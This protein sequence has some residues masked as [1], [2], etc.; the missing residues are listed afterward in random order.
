MTMT[1]TMALLAL[2]VLPASVRAQQNPADRLAEVLPADV[3]GQVLDVIAAAQASGLPGGAVANLALEGV[4]KGR[5]SDEVLAAVSLLVSDMGR[6]QDAL[7]AAGHAPEGGEIEAATAAIRMGVDGQSISELAR[8][9]PSGRS[10]AVPLLVMGGLAERG[11]PSDQALAA[12][13]DR[14]A[15]RADD[16]ALI[17]D[18]PG[19][20]R[21]LGPD[22]VGAGLAGGLAGFQV[23]VPGA[24]VP[25]G[26]Q[27][28]RG[29]GPQGHGRGG[30]PPGP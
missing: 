18:F 27:P 17:G 12:V 25:V 15:A 9:G 5:S 21:G 28:D 22:A 11:L 8:T 26:P 10:L 2:A 16:A 29:R 1:R 23:P 13:R 20:G 6:A 24:G 4:A 19:M 14:L 30:G 7:L 3:V